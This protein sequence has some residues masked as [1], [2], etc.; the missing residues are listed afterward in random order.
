M[1]FPTRV[2]AQIAK[3]LEIL[4]NWLI[5][6]SQVVSHHQRA[7]TRHEDHALKV[8]QVHHP[9]AGN[10]DLLPRQNQTEASDGL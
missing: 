5:D 2:Q 8:P 4:F 1:P 7:R 3:H 9:P 6:G 10:H